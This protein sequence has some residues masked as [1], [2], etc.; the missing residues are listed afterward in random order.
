MTIFKNM[1]R[2]R[3]EHNM[4]REALARKLGVTPARLRSREIGREPIRSDRVIAMAARSGCSIDFLLGR[5]NRMEY[6]I[7]FAS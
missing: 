5:S 4:T 1:E 7:S 3:I 2:M 6:V